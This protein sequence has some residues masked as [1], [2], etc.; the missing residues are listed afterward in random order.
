MGSVRTVHGSVG[1]QTVTGHATCFTSV[2]MVRRTRTSHCAGST[3]TATR[4]AVHRHLQER[5]FASRPRAVLL[6]VVRR[7]TT[8]VVKVASMASGLKVKCSSRTS[9][10]L[11]LHG[12]ATL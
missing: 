12:A 9:I 8:C 5:S 2:Q 3:S 4:Q 6:F 7:L 1:R 10:V 11:A